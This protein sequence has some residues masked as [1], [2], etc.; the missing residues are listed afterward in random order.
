M[1]EKAYRQATAA[2]QRR[3]A[4]VM[5][6]STTQRAIYNGYGR[7][8]C[9]TPAVQEAIRRDLQRQLADAEGREP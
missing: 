3:A 7:V 9:I 1:S 4:V 6:W 5:S 2:E 8:A